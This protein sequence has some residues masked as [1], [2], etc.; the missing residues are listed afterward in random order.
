M[1]IF[2]RKD[3]IRIALLFTLL[4]IPNICA[5][6]MAADM[7]GSWVVRIGYLGMVGV[8]LLLPA[9]FFKAR[10]YFIL[11]GLLNFLFMP[12]DIAS[13]YLNKQ[14]TSKLFLNSIVNTDISEATELLQSLW[15]ICIFVLCL[16]GIY[17]YLCTHIPN[18][19]L[20]P[21]KLRCWGLA[22][23]MAITLATY[24]A[25][26]YLTYKISRNATTTQVLHDSWDKLGIKFL[27]I[28]PYNLYIN[29]YQLW[30]DKKAWNKVQEEL[31]AFSFGITKRDSIDNKLFILYIGEAARYDHFSINNYTKNTTPNLT[32][33]TNI[34][35]LSSIYAQA[36]LTNSSIPFIL[37]RATADN[38]QLMHQEKSILEVFQE[39]GYTTAFISKNSYT[40][41]TMRIMNSCDYHYI[42]SRGL[43]AVDSY[44]IDLVKHLQDH[45][46]TQG[47]FVV[48]HSLGSHFKYSLRYPA[49]AN[50]YTPSL[51]PND[52]YAKL[53][54]EHKE[55]LI[56]AYDN[57]IRYT[58]YV[59]GELIQWA[60]SL[61]QQAVVMYISDHGESFWDDERKLSLHGSYE[62]CE[63]EYHVP[64]FVWYSDEYYQAYPDKIAMIHHNKDVAQNSSIVFSTLSDMANISEVVD[65]TK[66][67]CSPYVHAIDSFPV[68]N[69]AG[70]I[71]NYVIQKQ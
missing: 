31:D 48:L 60:D 58:D 53:T 56:N 18:Q 3:I 40:P 13:L 26:T 9:L 46:T 29:A 55:I 14:S 68:L 69:G 71:K 17:A 36:N 23:I 5:L 16:W 57:S 21:K 52:S 54:E 39:A 67:L 51:A 45:Y 41:F 22:A 11:E 28:Y 25:I 6:F 70:D 30:Q 12:I 8:C 47:Q 49:E 24:S 20:L 61:N 44:D 43:D 66:S 10:T 64:C 32:A 63:A 59:L 42:F 4:L 15:P 50:Y 38:Q 62:L 65:S 33:L 37:T 34:I 2:S 27:K 1:T 7:H 35:P 19:S